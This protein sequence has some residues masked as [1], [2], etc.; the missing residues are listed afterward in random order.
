MKVSVIIENLKKTAHV[1]NRNTWLTKSRSLLRCSLSWESL[2]SCA[3]RSSRC[4]I[5]SL[6]GPVP[7]DRVAGRRHPARHQLA[8]DLQGGEVSATSALVA[9]SVAAFIPP[10][11]FSGFFGPE[12][13][14][15]GLLRAI[16]WSHS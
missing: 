12:T 8:A 15:C 2:W 3:W 11:L 10:G 5:S 6:P 14:I 1:R 16:S 7:P 4:F 9:A 13:V